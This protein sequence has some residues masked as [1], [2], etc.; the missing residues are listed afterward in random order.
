MNYEKPS[1]LFWL[2]CL[3]L[4]LSLQPAFTSEP[5]KDALQLI[6][7]MKI[8]LDLLSTSIVSYKQKISDLENLISQSQTDLQQ[9]QADLIEQKKLLTDSKDKLATMETR[10]NELKTIYD[11][12]NYSYKRSIQTIKYGAIIGISII[13]A[14]G[15]IIAVK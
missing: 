2:A 11:N 5:K 8:D 14:E 9:S 12:L 13:I 4:L 7:S 3:C 10:Y 6:N 15:I 1:D